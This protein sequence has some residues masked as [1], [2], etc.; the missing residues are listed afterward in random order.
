MLTHWKLETQNSILHIFSFLHKLSFE[1]SFCF[2]FI[3]GCQISFFNFKNR[4]LFLETK[5]KGKKQ[6]SDIPLDF[7]GCRT[8]SII[9][10]LYTR[11]YVTLSEEYY[12]ISL[13]LK[14]ELDKKQLLTLLLARL[15]S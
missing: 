2:M 15:C 14:E 1:N 10:S 9:Y 13:Y 5:N 11:L 4:K 12:K 6:L 8:P 3:L 7:D